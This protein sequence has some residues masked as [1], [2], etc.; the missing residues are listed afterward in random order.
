MAK[1]LSKGKRKQL[2]R[3]VGDAVKGIQ[4]KQWLVERLAEQ[5]DAEWQDRQNRVFLAIYC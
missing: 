2:I 1:R 5:R 4:Q 3:L